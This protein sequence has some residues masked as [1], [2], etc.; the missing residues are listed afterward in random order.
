MTAKAILI[1]EDESLISMM[2]EDFV[3]VLGHV[4]AI[5]VDT[6]E[7]GLAAVE[8]GAFDIAI[9]DVNLRDRKVSWPIADA[10]DAAGKPFLFTTGGDIEVPPERHRHRLFLEKPFTLESVRKAIESLADTE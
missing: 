7:A 10:L 1:V 3:E 6:L 8:K 9:L 5:V 4:P 2:L